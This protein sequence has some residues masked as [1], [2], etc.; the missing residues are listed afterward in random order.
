MPRSHHRKKHKTQLRQFKHEHDDSALGSSTAKTKAV[1]VFTIIGAIIGSAVA[2]F[3]S[4]QS[5]PWIISW[6]IPGIIAGYFIGKR[7]DT[8]QW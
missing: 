8:G 3:A 4:N 7:I 5:V 6:L 2:F 1:V